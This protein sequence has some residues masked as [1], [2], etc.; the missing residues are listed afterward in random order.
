MFYSPTAFAAQC[1]KGLDAVQVGIDFGC[2]GEDY[3]G[4]AFNPIYDIA[5]AI[6]RFLSVGV[7]MVVIGSIIFA[8]VQYSAS[9]GNPQATQAA[10]KRITGAISA[11]V[12]YMFIFA[13]ANFLIPGGMFL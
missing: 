13:I 12:I 2:R 6:F 10:I 8:G 7:G 1:G 5:F 3:P 9:R 11:L 4:R